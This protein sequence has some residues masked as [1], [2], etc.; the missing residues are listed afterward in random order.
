VSED[1]SPRDFYSSAVA[2][3]T[4]DLSSK[5][6]GLWQTAPGV[7]EADLGEIDP[8]AYVIRVSQ[9]RPGDAALGRTLGLV[10]PTAAEYRALGTNEASLATLRAATG[11]GDRDARGPGRRP[12]TNAASTDLWPWLPVLAMLLAAR[13]RPATGVGRPAGLASGR[14]LTGGSR[15]TMAPRTAGSRE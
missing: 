13:Y 10:A 9:T 12:A 14:W 6:V 7:Y 15:R 5:A 4:P 3:T 2:M 11:G 8:G 1:G